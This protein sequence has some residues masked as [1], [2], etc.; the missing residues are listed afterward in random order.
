M[1]SIDFSDIHQTD[2]VEHHRL[3]LKNAHKLIQHVG[4]SNFFKTPELQRNLFFQ[5][6]IRES[7]F[8]LS[9]GKQ[10]LLKKYYFDC[11]IS[12]KEEQDCSYQGEALN[13]PTA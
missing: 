1:G 13:V 4:P 10:F 7:I 2:I 11:Q 5:F 9:S 3:V 12:L 8:S 6:D